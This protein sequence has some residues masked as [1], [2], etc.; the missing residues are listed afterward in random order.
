[1]APQRLQLPCCSALGT[2]AGSGDSSVGRC[3]AG[4]GSAD[5]AVPATKAVPGLPLARA[6]L[7][8]ASFG[9]NTDAQ[10]GQRRDV[11]TPRRRT[12]RVAG[13]GASV[14]GTPSGPLNTPSRAA[15]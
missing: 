4:G 15:W 1:Q 6:G 12:V 3:A 11:A 8:I 7:S 10:P 14:P 13:C 9:L 5:G 2:G